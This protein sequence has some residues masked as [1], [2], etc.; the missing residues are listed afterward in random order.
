MCRVFLEPNALKYTAGEQMAGLWQPMREKKKI[1]EKKGIFLSL[2]LSVP[3]KKRR[4]FWHD[5]VQS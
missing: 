4:L 2:R 1:G 3:K 5:G